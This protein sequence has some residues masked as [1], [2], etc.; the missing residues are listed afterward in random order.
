LIDCLADVRAVVATKH[1][2]V[3]P[4]RARRLGIAS[5][6]ISILGIVITIVIVIIIVS[7]DVTSPC[8]PGYEVYGS[9]YTW[10]RTYVGSPCPP[11][12]NILK[13]IAV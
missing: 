6:V 5:L 9:C 2:V 12:D 10:S 1:T 7:V 13:L 11:T 4:S 3:D 8:Y